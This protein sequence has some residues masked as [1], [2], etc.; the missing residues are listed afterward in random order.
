MAGRDKVI[1]AAGYQGCGIALTLHNDSLLFYS[2]YRE[3]G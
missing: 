1:F 3:T 2:L